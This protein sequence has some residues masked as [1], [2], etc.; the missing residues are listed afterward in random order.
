[1]ITLSFSDTGLSAMSI[2]GIQSV[3]SRYPEIE[4]AIL[5]GSRA[6]GNF[7]KGSDIDRTLEGRLLTLTLLNQIDTE[8]DELLLPYHIDLSIRHKI[9]NTDLLDHIDRVGKLFYV[10]E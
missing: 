4:K 7:R 2:E 6:K 1:M 8:L 3:F 9:K 10:K 5:Y